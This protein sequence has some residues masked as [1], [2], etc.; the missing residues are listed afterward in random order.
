[1]RFRLLNNDINIKYMLKSDM[2]VN[3]E[4]HGVVR[5]I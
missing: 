3:V 4:M 1:M 5:I 2:P